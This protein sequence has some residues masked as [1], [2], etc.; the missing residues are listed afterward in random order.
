MK[1]SQ[2]TIEEIRNRIY[3]PDLIRK[4]TSLNKRNKG[5]CPFHKEHN[6]S[7]S[8]DAKKGHWHCFGSCGSGGDLFS[9]LMK[10]ENITFPNAVKFLAFEAGVRLPES[11]TIKETLKEKWREKEILLKRVDILEVALNRCID[12]RYEKFRNKRKNLPLKAEWTV[13]EYLLEQ[14]IDEEFD[15][16]EAWR[17]G[18]MEL[19]EETRRTVRHGK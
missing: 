7:F 12:R 1:Y 11:D 6:P 4:Y 17:G 5:L 18:K 9:F 16:I 15:E 8:V 19:L 14:L 13:K 10:I 2:E 3:L